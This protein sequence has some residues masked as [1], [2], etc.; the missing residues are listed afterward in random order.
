MDQLQKPPK[1]TDYGFWLLVGLVTI[2]GL[3]YSG[4]TIERQADRISE[5]VQ[6]VEE[7]PVLDRAASPI[8]TLPTDALESQ[9]SY[10]GNEDKDQQE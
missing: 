8:Q 6:V 10:A 2:V 7:Q 5:R 4:S 3:W 9:E 1:K